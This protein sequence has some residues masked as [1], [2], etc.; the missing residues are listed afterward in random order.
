[1]KIALISHRLPP[2]GAGQALVIY[3]ILQNV[4]KARYVLVSPAAEPGSNL[5]G[6]YAS[7]LPGPHYELPQPFRLNRGDRFGLRYLRESVNVHLVIRQRARQIADIL[8][9]ERCEAVVACTG[10]L[11][12]LPA[13]YVAS[14]RVGVPYYAYIFDDYSYR[15]W[16]DP[17]AAFWARRFEP[18]LLRQAAKL[19]VPNE[20]LRDDLRKRYGVEPVVIHNSFDIAPYKDKVNGQMQTDGEDVRIVYTGEIYEAHYDAFRNMVKALKLL[21]R[22]RLKLHVYTNRSAEELDNLGISGPVVHHEGRT[23]TE[24]PSIQM[25]ADVLFLPL[26]FESPY[27]DLVRTSSTTKLGEYLAARRP[28]LVHAPKDAFVSWY[29]RKH[30]C[31]VV[32]DENDPSRL[33]EGIKTVL[34]DDALRQRLAAKGWQ[35]AETDFSIEESRTAF[36]RLFGWDEA[37]QR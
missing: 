25:N 24:V 5:T 31:G 8:R 2:S 19:I 11:T 13:A 26:A 7:Q 9:R 14:R 15:E 16:A 21:N 28:V 10:E 1:M 3:R 32:V 30:D 22:P 35:R 23:A 12:L 27:P 4:D 33:A 36:G 37:Q 17:I 20:A 29:F 6:T 18:R 34:C